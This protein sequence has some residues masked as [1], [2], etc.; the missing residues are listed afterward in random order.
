MILNKIYTFTTSST[1][2]TYDTDKVS[3][4]NSSLQLKLQENNINFT[5]AF[6]ST[7]GF[8][9]DTDLIE[10]SSGL[11][12]Q[13]DTRPTNA[14]FYAGYSS[15]I[16]GNWGSG[17]LTGT[18]FGSPTISSGAL[19]LSNGLKYLDY[20]A[21][22]NADSQQTGCVRFKF[23][24][25]YLS[26]T[27]TPKILF[28]ITSSTGSLNNLIQLYHGVNKN[29]AFSIYNATGIPIAASNFGLWNHIQ[30]QK[31]EIEFNYDITNGNTRL[32]VDG[33]QLGNISTQL[34]IR[35]TNI[36][37]F[38][39]GADHLGGN[40]VSGFYSDILVFKNIQH[41]STSYTLSW[42]T[43]YETIYLESSITLP[44]MEHTGDGSIL[45]FNFF[46]VSEYNTP[47]Y[48]LQ[49]GRSG[50]YLYYSTAW[51]T[52]DNTYNQASDAIVF[53]NNCTTLEVTGEKYGQFKIIFQASNTKGYVSELTANMLVNNGYSTTIPLVLFT[54]GFRTDLLYNFTESVSLN[55][56]DKTK[57]IISNNNIFY[58]YSTISNDWELSNSGYSQSS[59]SSEINSNCT[60]FV[61]L[62]SDI[63]LGCFLYSNDG[64]TTPK[65]S[66]VTFAYDFNGDESPTL[67]YHVYYGYLKTI[68]NTNLVSKNISVRTNYLE[69][70][71]VLLNDTII[72]TQTQSDGYW[73]MNIYYENKKPDKLYWNIDG[74]NYITE[75]STNTYLFS[76]LRKFRG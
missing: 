65:L 15:D 71:Y 51:V 47:K 12:Q 73:E 5:Q 54:N 50:D 4:V 19:D 42:S 49:I 6:D 55:G 39:I 40:V 56:S 31:Y 72:T 17:I 36:N 64:L 52:S 62:G 63:N 41:T 53:N 18:G 58:Y 43:I 30:N 69:G 32:F 2:Y 33:V 26:S 44:E 13:K 46:A 25:A 14:T 70:K 20:S 24:P 59:L 35:S 57:Y 76:E 8:V 68:D 3:V 67:D 29:L 10:F 9:Y 34:G 21:I 27:T 61:N 75:F 28:M 48:L 11:V 38:R 1:E 16:N 60:S 37:L 74:K 66:L 45:G 22:S 23:T 7:V